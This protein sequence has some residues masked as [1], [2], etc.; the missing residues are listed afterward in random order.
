MRIFFYKFIIIIIGLFLLYQLTIGYTVSKFQQ[1]FYSIS[2]KEESEFLK[3][4]LRKEI[5]NSLKKDKILNKN[6]TILIR[7]FYNKISTEIKNVD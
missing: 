2:I 3:N 6:D 5:R 1:K 7:D 4:K